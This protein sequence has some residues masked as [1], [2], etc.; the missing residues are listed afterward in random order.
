[1]QE[2]LQRDPQPVGTL[3]DAEQSA[4]S[5]ASATPR[6]DIRERTC[7]QQRRRA[8]AERISAR[9]SNPTSR[10]SN[11]DRHAQ[12]AVRR[13]DIHSRVSSS[14]ASEPAS[15]LANGFDH[16]AVLVLPSERASVLEAQPPQ[17]RWR[18]AVHHGQGARRRAA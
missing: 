7:Q 16:M 18:A 5:K 6:D 1:M 8:R 11:T 17:Q 3:S 9:S 14:S 15:D 12:L 4:E 13:S 10:R 2:R